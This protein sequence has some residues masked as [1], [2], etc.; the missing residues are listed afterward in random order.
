MHSHHREGGS[1]QVGGV[2][3]PYIDQRISLEL[4]PESKIAHEAVMHE[5]LEAV[6]QVLSALTLEEFDKA[7]KITENQLGFVKHREAMQRQKPE[8]FPAEYHDLAM[9]HH[10]AAENLAQAIPSHNLKLILPHLEQTVHACVACHRM[11]K[12]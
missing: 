1:P 11:Y 2:E 6:Y 12:T 3:Q 8:N 9:A 5:H 4:N 7:K 10:R